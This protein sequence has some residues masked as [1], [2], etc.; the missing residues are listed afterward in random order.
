[1]E[2]IISPRNVRI[3]EE[4][5]VKIGRTKCDTD[6]LSIDK[7]ANFFCVNIHPNESTIPRL[8]RKS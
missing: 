6:K 2:M 3:I 5:I 8:E 7:T 1:M 4:L